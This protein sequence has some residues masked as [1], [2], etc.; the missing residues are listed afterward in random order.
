[1]EEIVNDTVAP[2]LRDPVV[3]EHASAYLVSKRAEG[4]GPEAS[5]WLTVIAPAEAEGPLTAAVGRRLTAPDV[6]R[7]AGPAGWD[8]LLHPLATDYRRGLREATDIALDLHC[9]P[10]D[11]LREHQCVLIR[12][13]CAPE[14]PRFGLHAYL[15]RHSRTY[16]AL[17]G[18][19]TRHRDL[20]AHEEFWTRLFTPG[21]AV[22]LER[23]LLWLFN[24]VLGVTPRWWA[25]PAAVAA[26]LGIEC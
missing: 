19:Q 17:A 8:L 21:P 4:A 14:D 1:M 16:V 10:G 5:V 7:D 15:E 6:Y 13:A 12:L 22:Q 11:E 9:R 2:L 18:L 3:R 23:P 26:R 24:L 25:E 20:G